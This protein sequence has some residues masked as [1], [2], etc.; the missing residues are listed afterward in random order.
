M[1]QSLIYSSMTDIGCD[2][3]EFIDNPNF[4][5]S[6]ELKIKY[7][8][9]IY[10]I[11]SD[12]RDSYIQFFKKNAI[13]KWDEIHHEYTVGMSENNLVELCKRVVSEQNKT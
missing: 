3:L 13:G 4:F 10:Q 9:Y 6:W 8:N 1:N 7:K 5:G 12:G 11:I 2:I